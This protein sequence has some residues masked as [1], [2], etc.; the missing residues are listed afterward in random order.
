MFMLIL[1][2]IMLCYVMLKPSAPQV[3]CLGGDSKVDR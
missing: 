3:S 1:K 2:Y